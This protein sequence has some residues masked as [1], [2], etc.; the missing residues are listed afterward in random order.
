M[1]LVEDGDAEPGGVGVGAVGVTG[2]EVVAVGIGEGE[3]AMF[4]FVVRGLVLRLA[5]W[6]GMG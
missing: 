4:Y 2:E 6:G 3:E 5:L 1:Q